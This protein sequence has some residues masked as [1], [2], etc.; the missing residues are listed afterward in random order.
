MGDECIVLQLFLEKFE[1]TMDIIPSHTKMIY[2]TTQ[3]SQMDAASNYIPHL[4]DDRVFQHVS[5]Y[6]TQC[7]RV[8]NFYESGTQLVIELH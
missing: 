1:R 2:F 3:R 5:Y 7:E 6:L 8:S 4:L